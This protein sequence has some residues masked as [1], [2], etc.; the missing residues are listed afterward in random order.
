MQA[1]RDMAKTK[2]P[3]LDGLSIEY[4][5]TFATSLTIRLSEMYNEALGTGALPPSLRKSLP[6]SLPKLKRDLTS[7]SSYRPI[8]ILGVDY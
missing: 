7:L 6:V 4:Y 1:I 2:T 3:G 8:I 5:I